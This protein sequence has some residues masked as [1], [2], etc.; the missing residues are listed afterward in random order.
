M[1][2][3]AKKDRDTNGG[4]AMNGLLLCLLVVGLAGF[5]VSVLAERVRP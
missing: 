5:V 2:R 1:N 4:L 3:V